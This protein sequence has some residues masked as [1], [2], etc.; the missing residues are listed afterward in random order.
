[1]NVRLVTD[2]VIAKLEAAGLTVNDGVRTDD[3]PV[4][5]VQE[6]DIAE[7][8]GSIAQ[9]EGWRDVYSVHQITCVGLSRAQVQW[10]HAEVDRE[11]LA[12]VEDARVRPGM[13][14]GARPDHT[15]RDPILWI[16]TPRYVVEARSMAWQ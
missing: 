10:L 3:P 11:M 15:T 14:Q 16:S 7:R 12:G 6:I 13:T 2:A 9:G 8:D 4:V 5:V 1:M